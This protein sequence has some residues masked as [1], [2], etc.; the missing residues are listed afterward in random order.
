MKAWCFGTHDHDPT[1][2]QQ[3]QQQQQRSSSS[4]SGVIDYQLYWWCF[5]KK[6]HP[7]ID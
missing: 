4:W 2:K 7:S 6:H 5:L 3:Q 1:T